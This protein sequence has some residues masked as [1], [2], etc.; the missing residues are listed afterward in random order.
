LGD[1][2]ELD[3]ARQRHLESA[4]AKKAAGRPPIDIIAG[5]L[6]ALG[7]DI[8]QGRVEKVSSEG[9]G[10]VE[11]IREWWEQHRFGKRVPVAAGE[12]ML[13]RALLGALDI[14]NDADR[15]RQDWES[16]LQHTDA[17]LELKRALGGPEED[18]ARNRM[19]RAVELMRL[20]RFSE[21]RM[22]LEA[23]LEI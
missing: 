16:A 8:M 2:S 17:M 1:V 6:E 11:Q 14:A 18:I 7:I 5:E 4:E 9:Q 3:T 20:G 12:E 21:A 19:N 23:C 10:R 13:V 15:A 22:E